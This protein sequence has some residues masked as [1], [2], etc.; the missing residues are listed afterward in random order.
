MGSY[1][2]KQNLSPPLVAPGTGGLNGGGGGGQ[3]TLRQLL[4][5][6]RD[7]LI[8]DKYSTIKI[9]HSTVNPPTEYKQFMII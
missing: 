6:Q 3:N 9:S 1:E 5:G 2:N 7:S 4:N 8:I